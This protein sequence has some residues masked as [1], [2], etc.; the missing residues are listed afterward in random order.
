MRSAYTLD[1]PSL[2]SPR[3][4][5]AGLQGTHAFVEDLGLELLFDDDDCSSF[6][7]SI[8]SSLDSA[9]RSMISCELV[10]SLDECGG[11]FVDWT[12]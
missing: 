3:S 8:T 12:I 7:I 1:L 5:S 6:V 2:M 9:V 10:V 11:V 4:I